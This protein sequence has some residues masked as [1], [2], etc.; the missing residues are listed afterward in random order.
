MIFP[1]IAN[2]DKFNK[3]YLTCFLSELIHYCS[4]I[5]TPN[6]YY[7]GVFPTTLGWLGPNP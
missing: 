5:E 3:S 4:Q 7:G 1:K 6:V 2:R